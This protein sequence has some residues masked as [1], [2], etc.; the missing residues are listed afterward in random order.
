V[1]GHLF[2]LPGSFAERIQLLELVAPLKI[3][4]NNLDM[5]YARRTWVSDSEV[6]TD[7]VYSAFTREALI[8]PII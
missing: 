2:Q 7:S 1:P 6:G 4:L 8:G 5:A 3:A